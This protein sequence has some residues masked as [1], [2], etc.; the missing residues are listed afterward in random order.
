MALADHL[1]HGYGTCPLLLDDVTVHADATRT[2]EMLGL[3]LE[4]AATRQVVV[5]SQEQQVADWAAEHLHGRRHAVRR[6]LA[7]PV[8]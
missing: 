7:V 8:A 3:L 1:T 6:L 5:F 4:L 2:R